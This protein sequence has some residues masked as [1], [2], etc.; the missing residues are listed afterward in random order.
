MCLYYTVIKCLLGHAVDNNLIREKKL[1]NAQC[2]SRHERD[3]M[4]L[5]CYRA[6]TVSVGTS[7]PGLFESCSKPKSVP[8]PHG[9]HEF[10]LPVGCGLK[11][12]NSILRLKK[13]TAFCH[14][15]L[16]HTVMAHSL[17]TCMI[18]SKTVLWHNEQCCKL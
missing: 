10:S 4:L 14:L 7:D 2:S 3:I 1:V 9:F 6:C 5:Y 13:S 12:E 17:R 15:R 11:V 16:R 18:T 8:W